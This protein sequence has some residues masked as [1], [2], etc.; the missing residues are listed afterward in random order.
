MEIIEK[1]MI[2]AEN[3]SKHLNKSIVSHVM[4]QLVQDRPIRTNKESI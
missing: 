4:Q 3:I 2:P 1:D